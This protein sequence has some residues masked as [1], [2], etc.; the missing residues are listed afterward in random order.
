MVSH[1][2]SPRLAVSLQLCVCV[3]VLLAWGFPAIFLSIILPL[4][5]PPAHHSPLHTSPLIYLP[6]SSSL[7]VYCTALQALHRSSIR[8]LL[9]LPFS[10]E[11][12][13]NRNTEGDFLGRRSCLELKDRGITHTSTQTSLSHTH[14]E[15][16]E[17][18]MHTW[19]AQYCTLQ[20]TY[21]MTYFICS[22]GA[23]QEG[24]TIHPHSGL[25]FI[26]KEII[27][28]KHRSMMRMCS[29]QVVA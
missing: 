13:R 28:E 3:S 20:S 9:S 15:V 7:W 16:H 11:Q 19:L 4:S 23:N 5:L 29:E 1:C 12:Q 26:R 10:N 21:S 2:D 14:S 6:P 24:K 17:K 8:S 27:S 25:S 18:C 22:T